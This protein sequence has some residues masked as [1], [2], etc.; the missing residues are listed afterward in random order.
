MGTRQWAL[1]DRDFASYP[2]PKLH[3]HDNDVLNSPPTILP[4]CLLR[5]P[6]HAAAPVADLD[7]DVES[8]QG[9]WIGLDRVWVKE[10]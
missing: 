10:N 7:D 9:D 2:T 3:V 1:R 4:H 8:E 5:V 6:S